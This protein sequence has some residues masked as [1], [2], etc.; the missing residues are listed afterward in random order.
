LLPFPE[1]RSEIVYNWVPFEDQETCTDPN[2]INSSDQYQPMI[3]WF[4]CKEGWDIPPYIMYV[5]RWLTWGSW[6]GRN[7]YQS[8]VEFKITEENVDTTKSSVSVQL[9]WETGS[10]LLKMEFG[11]E[12]AYE[13]TQTSSLE[14]N[15]VVPAWWIIQRRPFILYDKHFSYGRYKKVQWRLTLL[16]YQHRTI[17]EDHYG[18]HTTKVWENYEGWSLENIARDGTAPTPVPPLGP[19][20]FDW[21]E[22]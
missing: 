10:E 6:E 22:Y 15:Y 8:P 21:G 3:I 14:I 16:G 9:G 12:G 5:E 11:V 20:Q 7:N 17:Y 18:V 19:P 13:H 1:E 2:S 4:T